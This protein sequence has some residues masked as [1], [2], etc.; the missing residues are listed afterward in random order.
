MR[1][2]LFPILIVVAAIVIIARLFYLQ[3]V[4]EKYKLQAEN[5]A[6][7]IKYEFPERGYIYDRNGKLMVSNQPSYDIM[8][9]P[10]DIEG[11]DTVAFCQALGIDRA[12]F[13][14]HLKRA[15]EYSPWLP[16]PFLTQLNK[17]E[18][19]SFQEQMRRFKGFYI[20]K[21]YLRDYQTKSGANIFG[22][23]AQVNKSEIAKNPYYKSGDLIGKNGVELAYEEILKGVKGVKRLQRDKHNRE[24]GSYKDGIYDTLPQRGKDIT[25]T[26]DIALQEYGD[27]L[28]INKRG[29]VVALD[30]K[31]GEILALVSSPTFD[32]AILVGRE[33]SKNYNKLLKDTISQPLFD[34]GLLAQ[35]VP[36]S[37]FKI[38][39]ALVGLQEGVIDLNSTF[40]CNY[41]FSYGGRFMKC[42]DAGHINL[43]NAI[44]SSCNTYFANTYRRSIDKYKSGKDG[45]DV[46]SKH[47]KSFGLG[48]FLGYDLPT[49]KRGRI[50]D[51]DYYMKWYKN[52]SWGGATTISNAIGQGEIA[53]TPIQLATMMC[54][55]ANRG[56]YYTPH[57]IKKIEGEQIQKKFVERH[58]T[59]IDAKYFA[60]IIE[61]LHAVYTGGTARQLQ[62]K[63]INICGK[64]GT[65]ENYT[66]I[67][68]VRTQLTDH[69]IFLAFAPKED[70]QIVVAVFVENGYWGARYAGPIATLMIEKYLKGEISRTDLEKRM[71]TETL[72]YEYEK[73][74]SG[75][76]FLINQSIIR[77]KED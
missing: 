66:K 52:G 5:N 76:P 60:P 67:N 45:M 29:G 1:K 31:T 33:R 48:E 55:V 19:A 57:I 30:P 26:I 62:V 2:L 9:I 17:R 71:F 12:Y 38:V 46:W 70:P 77:K 24:L 44:R 73:P 64:T 13:D 63:D 42:H 3:L 6:V 69:S 18:F 7:K 59:T 22:D 35:Y 4:D 14:S 25:L 15:I 36:G 50:P 39:T 23:I 54:A 27:S 16:S 8:V 61:G 72:E 11:L 28:M 10:R 41:G 53:T 20:Q 49:G 65:A 32:P 47:V 34:R 21:R 56:Y 37:T 40:A 75:K 74:Y 68:G 51:G 58:Q 43:H